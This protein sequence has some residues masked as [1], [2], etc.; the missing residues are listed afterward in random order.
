[1]RGCMLAAFV[2]GFFAI[3]GA[4]ATTY[5]G[6]LQQNV[7]LNGATNDQLVSADG[8]LRFVM[9]N[10]GNLVLYDDKR[11]YCGCGLGL[12]CCS[13]TGKVNRL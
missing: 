2:L 1:M 4:F 6:I 8:V 12:G 7:R 11:I 3:P 5:H 9:Q 10:D 13:T